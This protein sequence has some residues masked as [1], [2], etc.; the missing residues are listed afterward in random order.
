MNEYVVG[1]DIGSSKIC[2]AVGKMDKQGELQ[3]VG[4]T[5]VECIGLKK[6]VVVD[7]DGTSDAIKSCVEQLERMVDIKINNAYISLPGGNCELVYSKGVI[8]VSSEDREIKKNDIE[9]VHKAAKI[10]SL[11]SDKE[12]IGIIPMQYIVDG[13]DNIKDALGMSGIRLEVDAQLV[14]AQTTIVNNFYKSVNKSGIKVAGI[15]LQPIAL[16]QA[17]LKREEAKMCV[18][19]VDI[20]AETT[21]IAVYKD[22]NLCYTNMIPLGGSIITN[23]IA[24]CLKIPFSKA[25]KL[26]I[27]HGSIAK[28]IK[29]VVSNIKVIGSYNDI[30]EV[31]ANMLM[32]IIEARVEELLI[33]INNVLLECNYYEEISGIVIVG[34]GISLIK[35]INEFSKEIFEKSIRIGSPDYVGA[36]SPMF[37]VA[38]GIVKEVIMNS[39]AFNANIEVNEAIAC[40]KSKKYENDFSEEEGQKN[41]ITKIKDF[42]T[43]FF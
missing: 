24:V 32:E 18:A 25:E 40:S 4:V 7:I 5:S 14:V 34:G 17:I 13:Y 21:D 35:G 31:D 28:S 1:I 30:I 20:G 6:G 29:E 9:R 12:I 43:D 38:V 39:K 42:F 2:A 10:I 41:I 22:G 19:V 11:P 36:S 33:L 8:A 16:S 23:D 3:I 15:V 37:A 27:Q 26:K